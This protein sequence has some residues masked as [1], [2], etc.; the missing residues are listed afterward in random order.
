MHTLQ[1]AA[2]YLA[3]SLPETDPGTGQQYHVQITAIHSPNP[4]N[5]ADDAARE[6]PDYAAA[7]TYEQLKDSTEHV[8]FGKSS[9][10]RLIHPTPRGEEKRLS[11]F[12]I[13][14]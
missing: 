5:D 9:I 8:V 4:E 6:C 2:T 11:G 10:M 14:S 3:G 7:A 12:R 1:I 13:E